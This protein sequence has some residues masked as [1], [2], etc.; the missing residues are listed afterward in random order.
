MPQNIEKHWYA[1]WFDSPYYHTL[2]KGRDYKEAEFFIDN[3]I[4]FLK[5]DGQDRFL[6]LA[7][8]KGR[9]SIYLNKKG[10]DVTGTDL[11]PQSIEQAAL[12]SNNNLRFYVHDMR[13]PCRINY[14]NYVVNLFTSFGYFEKEKDNY[15]VISAI[16]KQLKPKGIVV[17]DFLNAH[18]V[19]ST[20][21]PQEVKTVDG[22]N[23]NI[24]R[25]VADGRIIKQ[26]SFSDAGKEYT[27][28]EK[29]QALELKHF[30]KY[31]DANKLKILN[32]LGDYG[33]NDFDERTSD[34]LIIIA[35]K[36]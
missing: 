24:K 7:C 29:V 27:F 4:S 15:A 28:E 26:I 32:L 30:E 34:R 20:L 22:I 2:Y 25:K 19:I 21:I 33:L 23:F 35:Q 16:Q 8:G 9:H 5:P 12:K 14:F 10:F 3:L 13:L 36:E 18:K 6:D 17:I 31:L 11:S 1:T